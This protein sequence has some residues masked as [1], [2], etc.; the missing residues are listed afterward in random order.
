MSPT[1]RSAEAF[2]AL[3]FLHETLMF[4]YSFRAKSVFP[5]ALYILA[6]YV[7]HGC[8]IRSPLINRPTG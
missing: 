1:A 4:S 7:P 3:I 5:A 8:S 2:D 6:I